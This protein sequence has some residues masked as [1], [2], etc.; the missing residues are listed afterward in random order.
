MGVYR[1]ILPNELW[2]M[3][4]ELIFPVNKVGQHQNLWV[5][6]K[7][8]LIQNGNV[9]SSTTVLMDPH[10]Q[11]FNIQGEVNLLLF[12]HCHDPVSP[13]FTTNKLSLIDV[14]QT[15]ANP[16]EMNR[17]ILFNVE[18]SWRAFR[19]LLDDKDGLWMYDLSGRKP[20]ELMKRKNK[21]IPLP[22]FFNIDPL[23][24]I[25]MTTEQAHTICSLAIIVMGELIT[26]INHWRITIR[27]NWALN[28]LSAMWAF[29]RCIQLTQLPLRGGIYNVEDKVHGFF[30]C[31]S[32][33][34]GA[35][36]YLL[37]TRGAAECKWLLRI[38]EDLIYLHHQANKGAG[39]INNIENNPDLIL[40]LND[41]HD[42]D[43]NLQLIQK[44]T[45]NNLPIFIT[46]Q[47][48]IYL[49]INEWNLIPLQ[50]RL[51]LFMH[52]IYNAEL[53]N[54]LEN[55]HPGANLIEITP[56]LKFPFT[57]ILA[58]VH[59]FA[60]CNI[61]QD[62]I[63]PLSI[64]LPTLNPS[65]VLTQPNSSSLSYPYN[66]LE[67]EISLPIPGP[68]MSSSLLPSDVIHIEQGEI[69]K[70][71]AQSHP[72]VNRITPGYPRHATPMDSLEPYRGGIAVPC[73]FFQNVANW[74]RE[75]TAMYT[76]YQLLDNVDP[77]WHPELLKHGWLMI[78]GKV[79]AILKAL[80]NVN[81]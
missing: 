58:P 43:P 76:T 9:P 46:P 5:T 49:E 53:M 38:N 19:S 55:G 25:L 71:L 20:L 36:M 7:Y 72:T 32:I 27:A 40:F 66:H 44:R 24:T 33:R 39:E 10:L 6:T 74:Q 67:E 50:C 77:H 48:S 34:C 65:K 14:N 16:K 57:E 56:G 3:G 13:S 22:Q 21:G 18:H 63:T 61:P 75:C 79:A 4:Y 60:G 54:Y 51:W 29:V 15:Q 47:S 23:L 12:I 45:L 35:P 2:V 28:F 30:I 11:G 80:V 59:A 68:V 52:W 64:H 73:S 42:S 70:E 62:K 17:P 78:S 81:L 41:L 26:F 37:N 8:G 31:H 69:S 1:G